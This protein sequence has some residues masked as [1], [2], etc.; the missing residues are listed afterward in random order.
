MEKTMVHRTK[1]ARRAVRSLMTAAVLLGFGAAV[2]LG[3]ESIGEYFREGV[4]LAV[5]RVLP[6]TF[7]FMVLSSIAAALIDPTVMPRITRAFERIFSVSG[8]G[9]GAFIIGNLT[10]FPIGAKLTASLYKEGALSRSEA[11]RLMAYSCNP[12]AAFT[13]AVVGGGML[14]D[15]ALGTILLLSVWLGGLVSAQL[16]REKCNNTYICDEKPRQKLDFIENVKSAALSSIY[17]IAFVT[18]FFIATSIIKKRVSSG[19]IRAAFIIALEVTGAVFFVS[20]EIKNIY[21][22]MSLS[23]L[24][25]GF[26]GL[27]VMAQVYA[28]TDGSGLRMRKYF[29]IKIFSALFSA[30]LAP[31]ITAIYAAIFG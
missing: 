8:A 29:Y 26:G 22:A 21:I 10:G 25:L 27:S 11:E 30:I 19:I 18:L 31:L 5:E 3:G 7:P 20:E 17:M 15:N 16:F 14:G 12:S 1:A 6:S 24:A 23:A 9:L 4:R 28:V 2:V 13:V